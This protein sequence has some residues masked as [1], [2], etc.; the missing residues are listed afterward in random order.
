MTDGTDEISRKIR[1]AKTDP[2]P[3]PGDP[4]GL[5]GRPE[6]GNLIGI[7]AALSDQ[8][9]ADVCAKFEG[10]QFSKF[11][12]EL[13]E[14]AVSVLGPVGEEMARLVKDPGYLDSVLRDGT[15]RAKAIA[16][17]ILDEIYDIVGFL[18]P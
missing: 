6:A 7:Y 1:K 5:E 14:L 8:S 11:K 4:N 2:E 9:A 16:N 12:E 3:L 17:P 15:D 18:R 10:A 13:T